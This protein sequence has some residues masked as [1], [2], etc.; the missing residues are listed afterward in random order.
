V[1]W[2]SQSRSFDIF[3][4]VNKESVNIVLVTVAHYNCPVEDTYER[5]TYVTLTDITSDQ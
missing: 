5:F 3:R 2:G 1:F 4:D